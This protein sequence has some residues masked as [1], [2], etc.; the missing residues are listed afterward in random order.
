M[1]RIDQAKALQARLKILAPKQILLPVKP[2][3]GEVK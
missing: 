3:K 1:S 2:R